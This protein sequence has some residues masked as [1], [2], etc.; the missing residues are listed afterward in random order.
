MGHPLI[1]MGV[2]AHVDGSHPLEEAS[3]RG[4]DLVQI[5]LTDPQ[6]WRKPPPRDDAAELAASSLPIVVHAPYLIN[7]A[8]DAS[9]IR[10]PSRRILQESCDAAAAIGAVG[11]VVH[12]GYLTGDGPIADAYPRWRKA[13]LELDTEVPVLIENTATGDNAVA[14]RLDSIARLWAEIGD[15]DPGF[16]L[17]TCHAWAGGEPCEDLPGRVREVTG[18]IDLVHCNDSRDTFDSH[19]DRHANIEKGQIPRELL[20][21]M[22]AE[23]Q[24]P[25][26]IE[27]P[28][29]VGEHLADLAWVRAH[30]AGLPAT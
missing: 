2:G 12:G 25:V 13:L 5:F 21:S 27:T 24:A 3:A 7:V 8:A 18:R 30:M 19:R 11:V 22:V 1:P 14:R 15:L 20:A 4:A 9:R 6:S 16:V 10:I 17:D 26:V 29:G 23:A 28:G